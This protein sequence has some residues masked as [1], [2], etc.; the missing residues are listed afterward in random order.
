M[1]NEDIP[2]E[3]II[4]SMQN[5]ASDDELQILD[6][7]LQNHENKILYSKIK[8][9][10]LKIGPAITDNSTD[11]DFYKRKLMKKIRHRRS[12]IF[13][14]LSKY[15]AVASIA[16]LLTFAFFEYNASQNTEQPLSHS[17]KSLGAKSKIDLGDG[18]TVWLHNNSDITYDSN[19]GK[20]YRNIKLKGIAYFDVSKNKDPLIVEVENI[21]IKVLGTKFNVNTEDSFIEVGLSE[22]I[23]ELHTS[24]NMI[25][26]R[27]GEKGMID[28]V[29]GQVNV[30]PFDG[31]LENSWAREQCLFEKQNLGYIC[32]YLSKWYN[33]EINVNPTI[34]NKYAFTFALQNEPLEEILRIMSKIQPVKYEFSEENKVSINP[35]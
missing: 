8:S 31:A 15:A 25:Q 27:P 22:G 1:K 24:N 4:L 29:T 10:W 7:W 5:E 30:I 17:F 28:R 2:W 32:E 6:L 33:V 35:I 34:L 26:L 19:Y 21:K 9:V 3:I 13:I 16:I 23:V 14:R 11:L 12:D 20:E 18:S